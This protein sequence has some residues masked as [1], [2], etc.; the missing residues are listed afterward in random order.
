[1][2]IVRIANRLKISLLVILYPIERK[3]YHSVNIP[4]VG[5]SNV[6]YATMQLLFLGRP[7]II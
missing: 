3:S 7:H 2:A 4:K 5:C 6:F 1:M